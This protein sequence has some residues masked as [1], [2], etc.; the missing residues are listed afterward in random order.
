M[1]RAGGGER[2]R[3]RSGGLK[4]ERDPESNPP[5]LKP[6]GFAHVSLF[7]SRPDVVTQ[8]YRAA[9]HCGPPVSATLTPLHPQALLCSWPLA[10]S[11]ISP[12]LI[13][14]RNHQN[15]ISLNA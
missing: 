1:N 14:L 7:A 4:K 12:F 5:D 10:S 6:L 13:L 2:W 8:P 11:P 3:G 15:R 9:G